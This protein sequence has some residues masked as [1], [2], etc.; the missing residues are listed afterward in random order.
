MT[1][2]TGAAEKH[3]YSQTANDRFKKSS[4]QWFF[5][6]IVLA[7]VLHF[8]LFQ[9]FPEL[10]ASDVS[11]GVN[12]FEAIELPPEVEI[13][14]PPEQIARPAVPVISATE[15]EEDITIAPTTFEENPVESLPPPPSD[16]SRLGDRP[17]FTPYTVRPEIKDRRRAVQI[18]MAHYPKILQDAGIGG[19]VYVWLF[20]D[21]N[22]RVQN[23]QVQESS[24][25][26]SLDAAAMEAVYEIEFTPALNMDKRVPVWVAFPI[27]FEV[28]I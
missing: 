12:E 22:G 24:G 4:N 6:S 14:P 25:N 5:G 2:E 8:G 21:T 26:E 1:D 27:L 16:V 7:T 19:T 15:L 18:V 20:I 28:P 9:F 23:A 13:P 3:V 10:T 17:V 11:F